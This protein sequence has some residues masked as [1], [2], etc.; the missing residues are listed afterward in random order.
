MEQL[1]S[2]YQAVKPG[3]IYGNLLHFIAG[4]L[5]AYYY[6]WS[7]MAFFGGAFG[8][9]LVIASACLMNNYLD[10][11]IDGYMQ[12]TRQRPTVQG[13]FTAWQLY[14][15]IM[16]LAILGFIALALTTNQLTVL[17]GAI[18]YGSYSFVYTYAKRKT[19]HSTLIGTVPGA[20]PA[21]AGY[22]AIGGT[23]D[24]AGALLFAIIVLWQMP[25][26]Y[27]IAL[28]R[29]NEYAAA[30]VPV[31]TARC[32]AKMIRVF[33]IAW[34]AVYV[35]TIG[36][37]CYVAIDWRVTILMVGGAV[38]WLMTALR[39]YDG[40]WARKVFYASLMLSVILLISAGLN[41]VFMRWV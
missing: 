5:F 17:L 22:T 8:T 7:W 10:R 3:I 13:V 19:I 25:H 9:S 18:A 41:F 26:F 21:L 2:F 31:I 37:F 39:T 24:A 36:V 28:F 15:A 20:L 6:T 32:S 34:I 38:W 14:T 12:R 27:A 30:R 16:I 33:M 11:D 1:R 23:I 35:V 40:N 29:K 4:A